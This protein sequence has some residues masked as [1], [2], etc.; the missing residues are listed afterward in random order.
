MSIRDIK[1]I[2]KAFKMLDSDNQGFI[3]LEKSK[4]DDGEILSKKFE[5]FKKS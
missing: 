1:N 5:I 3:K 2:N 4:I